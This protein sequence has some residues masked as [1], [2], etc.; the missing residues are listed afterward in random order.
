MKEENLLNLVEQENIESNNIQ[1]NFM[2][3]SFREFD[4]CGWMVEIAFTTATD[5]SNFLDSPMFERLFENGYAEKYRVVR[6]CDNQVV[7]FK[8]SE[9][10]DD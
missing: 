10:A 2:L 9:H 7:Y 1:S 5:V 3:E 4:D 6:L 8:E